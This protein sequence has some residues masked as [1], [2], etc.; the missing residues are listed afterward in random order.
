MSSAAEFTAILLFSLTIILPRPV[1]PVF[2]LLRCSAVPRQPFWAP[3]SLAITIGNCRLAL[4]ARPDG[5]AHRFP[6]RSACLSSLVDPDRLFRLPC[7]VVVPRLWGMEHVQWTFAR[8][9]FFKSKHQEENLA[10]SSYLKWSILY[11]VSET[12]SI[13]EIVNVQHR[14]FLNTHLKTKCFWACEVITN[15]SILS[16]SWCCMKWFSAS[17]RC[18]Y[19]YLM[20]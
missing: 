3:P 15:K 13:L 18:I 11:I 1:K 19:G 16:A 20:K 4:F 2:S 7:L 9:I 14:I 6:A 10:Q 5:V 8:V 12:N 17:V